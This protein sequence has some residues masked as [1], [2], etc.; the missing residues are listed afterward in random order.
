MKTTDPQ[1]ILFIHSFLRRFPQ[2]SCDIG[3]TLEYDVHEHEV[4]SGAF[5][6]QTSQVQTREILRQLDVV[7]CKGSME[8]FYEL[9]DPK[10]G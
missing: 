10:F 5:I 7:V 4:F 2:P 9:Y 3:E 6:A 8:P 1:L